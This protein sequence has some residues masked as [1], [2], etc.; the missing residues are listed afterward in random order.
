MGHIVTAVEQVNH[1]INEI[2]EATKEQSAGISQ[3]NRTVGELD[4]M[5]QQNA[6]LVEESAAAAASM[7]DQAARLAE[8]VSV[9][10]VEASRA[11]TV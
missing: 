8:L 5:T 6:A 1:I 3:V 2:T 4:G 7:K 11:T 9:F 10:R